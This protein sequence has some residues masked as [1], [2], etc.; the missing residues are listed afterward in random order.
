[1]A[2]YFTTR[3]IA[4]YSSN[5]FQYSNFQVIDTY[6]ISPDKLIQINKIGNKYVVIAVG[7]DNVNFITELDES[8]IFIR[9]QYAKE[10]MSFKQIL[11]KIRNKSE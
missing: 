10:N 8:E 7:K 9:D 11:D 3:F 2:A 5:Q 4:R 1:V 6:R